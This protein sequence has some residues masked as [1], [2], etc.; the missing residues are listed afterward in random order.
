MPKFPT[1]T[2]GI[3]IPKDDMASR[4]FLVNM[5]CLLAL[6]LPQRWGSWLQ[7][8]VH[9]VTLAMIEGSWEAKINPSCESLIR[10]RKGRVGKIEEG[11]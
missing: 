10:T 11:K 1:Q 4:A 9:G 2:M 8:L 6:L 5:T 3:Q 7:Y